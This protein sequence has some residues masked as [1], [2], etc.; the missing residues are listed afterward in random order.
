MDHTR[1]RDQ[2]VGATKRNVRLI[3]IVF[4]LIGLILFWTSSFYL[5]DE[6]QRH[7]VESIGAAVFIFGLVSML[8]EFRDIVDYTSR[9]LQ[10]QLLDRNYIQTLSPK[11]LERLKRLVDESI[12]GA[13]ELTSKGGVYEFAGEH[14]EKVLRMPYRRE[15]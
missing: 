12:V 8:L 13:S 11:E 4:V 2:E 7:F 9:V 5:D 3:A 10:E 14:V 6:S 15:M 1:V